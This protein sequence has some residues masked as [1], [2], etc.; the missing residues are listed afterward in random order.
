MEQIDNDSVGYDSMDVLLS[1]LKS[2]D[3]V[4]LKS[5]NDVS[6]SLMG[7]EAMLKKIESKKA[8]LE[9]DGMMINPAVVNLIIEFNRIIINKRL[10]KGRTIAKQRGIRMG[11]PAFKTNKKNGFK[12]I[13]EKTIIRMHQDGMSA[14]KIHKELGCNINMVLKVIK[15]YSK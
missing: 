5:L 3:I 12:Y 8:I 9:V 10:N 4:I 15:Y 11:R 6:D 14:N 13:N 2:G 7:L 1:E